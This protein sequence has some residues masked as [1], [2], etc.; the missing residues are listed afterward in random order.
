MK[1]RK[2]VGLV[3][4]SGAARG[5]AHLGVI[6]V[7]HENNIPI[8]I[9]TGTSIGALIG[10][11]YARGYTPDQLIEYAH[12]LKWI[13]ILNLIDITINQSGLMRGDR[14]EDFIRS[15][16]GDIHI[17]DLATPF[18]CQCTDVNTGRTMTLDK[19]DTVKAIRASIS[20]PGIF[21]PVLW[22]EHYL[23]DGGLID[24]VPIK[25][26]QHMGAQFIIAV[27]VTTDVVQYTEHKSQR[28]PSFIRRFANLKPKLSTYDVILQ[29]I[30][31]MEAEIAK[32]N[33]RLNP[34]NILIK[35]EID[36]FRL[37]EFYKTND[38]IQTG[39]EAAQAQLSEIQ[40][41]LM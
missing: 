23:V 36:Q 25:L 1:T 27:N 4:G 5:L 18:A 30:Y 2:K 35:P 34:P 16:I 29:S 8:D 33:L 37:F 7:L 24:P 20:V 13:K 31:I 3:L 21:S 38:L 9:I 40:K 32:H 19:G 39:I 22:N 14:I 41:C 26:A 17:E 6:K 10:A 11:A 28:K 15:I 12:T